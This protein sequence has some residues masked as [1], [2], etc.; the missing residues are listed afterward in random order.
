[1]SSKSSDTALIDNE[2]AADAA[3]LADAKARAKRYRRR[4]RIAVFSALGLV[5]LLAGGI[6]GFGYWATHN[7]PAYM[8]PQHVAKQR[9]GIVA[10]GTGAVR[11][12]V[13]VDYQC[14]DCKAFEDSVA[15]TLDQMV[16][17]NRITLVYHPLAVDTNSTTQ[18]AMRAA[19]S[20]GCASDLD[21]FLTYSNLLFREQPKENTAGLTDNQLVQIGGK[22]GMINPVF[23]ECLRAGTYNKWVASENAAAAKK[24]ITTTPTLLVDERSVA[25]AGTVPTLA[26]LKAAVG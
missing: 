13:Y 15:G 24:H 7:K 6:A 10:G 8:V 16:A 11:V 2:P 18:Y 21:D 14:P 22:A 9:D 20:V 3:A 26:E 19:A 25:P 12:D 4:G 1:M 17:A 23:A 5:L